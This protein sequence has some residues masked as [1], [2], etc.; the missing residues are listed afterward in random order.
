MAARSSRQLLIR[1]FYRY[2]GSE[3]AIRAAVIF[4]SS[5]TSGKSKG[6]ILSHK[7]IASALVAVWH[8]ST[9]GPNERLVGLPPFYHIFVRFLQT[10]ESYDR[11]L[12]TW[13]VL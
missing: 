12:Q 7:A 4:W 6:V 5:G 2:V 11:F 8:Y 1:D 9:L 13:R 10:C 3:N